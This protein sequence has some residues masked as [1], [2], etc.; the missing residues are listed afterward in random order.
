MKPAYW[1]RPRNITARTW[2]ASSFSV[3]YQW[4]ELARVKL[5][6]SPPIQVSGKLRSSNRATC[7]LSAVTVSTGGAA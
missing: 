3:K 2:A 7:W 5:E 6:I 4:P 1:A